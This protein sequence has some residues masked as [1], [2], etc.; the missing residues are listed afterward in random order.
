[1]PA[2]TVVVQAFRPAV[3]VVVQAFRPAVSVV[4]QAFRPA[5]TVV[6]QAFRP[7]VSGRPEGL[8]YF[9]SVF[10]M[11]SNIVRSYRASTRTW[12]PSA[13]VSVDFGSTLAGRK[14]PGA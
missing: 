3:T 7:A 13:R 4:V 1:M 5:A 9:S 8:H 12:T 10:A 11:R 6:V 14:N 2:A